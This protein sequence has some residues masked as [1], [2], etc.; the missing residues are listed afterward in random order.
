LTAHGSIR[1]FYPMFSC[2]RGPHAGLHTLFF[3]TLLAALTVA[4]ELNVA[5]PSYAAVYTWTDEKGVVHMTDR[6]VED[7]NK[8][9][10][11]IG[12]G[13]SQPVGSGS[14]TERI[15]DVMAQ[16][17]SDPKFAEL[18]K[19]VDEYRRSHSY[20]MVDYFVCIDMA[21]E[22][23][24][25]LKTKQYSPKVVAGTVKADTAGMEPAQMARTFDHA[26]VVVELSPGV[27]A[28][29]E[30]TGGFVVNEKT[31]NFE[32]YFQGLIFSNPR[33]AKDTDVLM[34]KKNESCSKAVD[35]VKDW[36]ANYAG[37]VPDQRMVQ[38][39]GWVDAKVAE[40]TEAQKQYEEL[41]KKQYRTLY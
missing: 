19:I 28:A 12:G 31:K 13:L 30:G 24:N 32:Y 22:L 11:E 17:R 36:K 39:K 4:F 26:W 23:F 7:P 3:V 16:A 10:K 40:C 21:L 41:I 20:S 6:K 27:H 14:R 5:C 29:L 35:I 15:L 34:R 38:T 8:N 37:R 2:C 18:H 33:Q 1:R 9:V 25:I